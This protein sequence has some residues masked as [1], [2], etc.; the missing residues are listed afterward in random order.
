[1][2]RHEN[3]E[4]CDSEMP[5]AVV[6]AA[7]ASRRKGLHMMTMMA[8]V[9]AVSARDASHTALVASTLS[10]YRVIRNDEAERAEVT[11]KGPFS[12]SSARHFPRCCHDRHIRLDIAEHDTTSKSA[13]LRLAL[14]YLAHRDG[15]LLPR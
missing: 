9:I 15:F 14:K 5:V 12:S 2:P 11:L 3:R 6:S 13:A 1:M 7:S 8:L 10:P 4:E